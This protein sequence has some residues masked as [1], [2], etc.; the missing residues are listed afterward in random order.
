MI[1]YII[2]TFVTCKQSFS[3]VKRNG[4]NVNIK[5]RLEGLF[6]AL[7]CW[8]ITVACVSVFPNKLLGALVAVGY[9][10]FFLCDE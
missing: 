5:A 10:L 2:K 3:R 9:G 8:S 7:I 1:K 4:G 6:I